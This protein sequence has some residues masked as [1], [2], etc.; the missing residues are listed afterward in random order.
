MKIGVYGGC[1]NPPHNVHKKIIDT[2]LERKILDLIIIVPVGDNYSKEA[3]ES[4]KKRKEML[5]LLIDGNDQI[6]ISDIAN[7]DCYYAY[8][9]LDY[10]QA[11]YSNN[12]L[13]FI[14][15]ADN[16]LELPTWHKYQYLVDNYQFLVIDRNKID[17]DRVILNNN[18]KGRVTKIEGIEQKL[19]S[20]F[21][22]KNIGQEDITRYLNEK[23]FEYIRKNKLYS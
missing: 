2:I 7:N 20:T 14:L 1:F 17:I 13:F 6:I 10:Y 22:R 19:S 23:V 4:F 3:L 16:L 8:Q 15:G 5:D 11:K 9:M 12:E 21:I 18:L